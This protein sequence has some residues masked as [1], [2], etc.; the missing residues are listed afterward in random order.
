MQQHQLWLWPILCCASI[1]VFIAGTQGDWPRSTALYSS[2]AQKTRGKECLAL[3]L[4]ARNHGGLKPGDRQLAKNCLKFAKSEEHRSRRPM[5]KALDAE[6]QK[7]ASPTAQG[8][9]VKQQPP[10]A[11]QPA[12][13]TVHIYKPPA[14]FHTVRSPSPACPIFYPALYPFLC[15][16]ERWL[17]TTT[18][19]Y[20][21]SP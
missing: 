13:V 17:Y 1:I 9:A 15:T 3:A 4:R 6:R 14:R 16:Q 11:Q 19:H 2:A 5:D 12:A 7:Q 20:A 8:D 18:E 21:R 10:D